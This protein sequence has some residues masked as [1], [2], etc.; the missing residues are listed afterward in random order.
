MDLVSC[1]GGQHFKKSFFFIPAKWYPVLEHELQF[2]KIT[3]NIIYE[4]KLSHSISEEHFETPWI[5]TGTHR[6]ERIK[7]STTQVPNKTNTIV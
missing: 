6:T 2:V 7:G 4:N 1:R 5:F 3:W